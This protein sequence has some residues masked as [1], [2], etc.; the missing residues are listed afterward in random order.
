MLFQAQSP[1]M[2]F[3][4]ILEPISGPLT[5]IV[6]IGLIIFVFIK[7][8]NY[9]RKLYNAITR[10]TVIYQQVAVPA[11]TE[12]SASLTNEEFFKL[13]W[14]ER[15]ALY[16]SRIIQLKETNRRLR[17]RLKKAGLPTD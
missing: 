2:M 9:N 13:S 6:V 1:G 7:R 15:E 10:P 3:R 17:A 5:V 4:D 11:P 8:R 12:D 16:K 14:K